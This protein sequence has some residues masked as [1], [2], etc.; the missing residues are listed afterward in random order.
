MLI[1]Q[2]SDFHIPT[3]GE[4]A[5]RGI[6]DTVAALAR[7][8]EHI[9]GLPQRPDLVLATGDLTNDGTAAACADLRNLLAPLAMPVYV[10]PGNHDD[11]AN[12]RAAFPDHKYL[13]RDG[14]FLHYTIEDWPL[15]LIGLDTVVPGEPGGLICAQRRE[16]LAERLA[17][18][19]DRPTLIFMHHPPFSI[20]IAGIDAMKCAGGAE[21]GALVQRHPQIERIVC[22]HVHRPAQIRWHGTTAST[23]ASTAAQLD[24][25]FSDG[26]DLTMLPE[27]A[28]CLLHLWQPGLGLVSH[29]SFIGDYAEGAAVVE[30]SGA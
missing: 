24:L 21:L 26:L 1:A 23:A 18:A 2:I 4:L 7:A 19:P 17:E 22:G 10:I 20:G 3:P 30:P 6:T 29:T 16:W 15:R 9:N 14:E 13:P 27:P 11:R 25:N 28:T 12:L 8:V 5:L